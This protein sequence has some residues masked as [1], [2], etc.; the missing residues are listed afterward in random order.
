MPQASLPRR[1][2]SGLVS[3]VIGG[4]VLLDMAAGPVL[5][6]LGRFITE[7]GPI[8]MIR[9]LSRRL[10]AYVALV[11]LVV[12]LAIA[13][14]AKVFAL[15][16]IGEGH[17]ISGLVTLAVAYIVSLLL[18]DTIY[19]GARPQLRSI[20]WFARL[21]DRVSAIRLTVMSA[22][23]TSKPYLAAKKLV[24]RVRALFRN[25]RMKLASR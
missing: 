20:A 2:S 10:P 25:R 18:V 11:A 14:P 15:Y 16:L 19:E 12:P 5:R 13:E 21:V 9:R 1:A 17:Y 7:S 4:F 23:R 24:L 22:V 3:T 8:E 6:P